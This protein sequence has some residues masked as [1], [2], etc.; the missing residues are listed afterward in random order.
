MKKFFSDFKAFI[1]RG[2]VVD[3]AVAVVIGGAFGAIITSLV[4]DII[5]PVIS[6]MTGG[7]KFTDWFVALDGKTY[8][9]LEAAQE[10]GASTLN[11]GSLISHIINFII[12]AFSIFVCIK[13]IEKIR[14]KKEEE[15]EAPPEPTKEE[16][17]LTEI[18]DLLA[19]Q[20]KEK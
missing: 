13:I 10:A 2:N 3:L 17:L 12:I 4:D 16:L 15:P 20:N 19:E 1:M 8:E 7:I 11:Y 18:R 9:T 5:M 6:L 14:R